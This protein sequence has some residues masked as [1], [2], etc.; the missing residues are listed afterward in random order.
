MWPL[1]PWSR[2]RIQ[3]EATR[4]SHQEERK[5]APALNL[6]PPKFEWGGPPPRRTGTNLPLRPLPMAATM[7][8]MEPSTEPTP[9]PSPPRSPP[10]SDERTSSPERFQLPM[11]RRSDKILGSCAALLIVSGLL[12]KGYGALRGVTPPDAES[13]RL[14]AGNGSRTGGDSAL[15]RGSLVDDRTASPGPGSGGP[16]TDRS[17]SPAGDELVDEWSPPLIRGGFGFF[18]GFAV[19]LVL[20]IFLRVSIVVVGLNLLM[21]FGLSYA[22]WLEVRWDMIDAQATEWWI[23]LEDQLSQFKTFIAG[24][25]PTV[26]LSGVG[27]FTGFRKR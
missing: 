17:E 6:D 25:L 5:R 21:L 14:V 10:M 16:S 23:S 12:L 11:L 3:I 18:V 4:I 2:P 15:P 26:G 22:G 7:I 20:R 24:S 19:G 8:S 9:Q 27:L 1:P 13:T